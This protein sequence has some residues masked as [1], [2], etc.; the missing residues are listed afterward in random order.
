MQERI[1]IF[2]FVYSLIPGIFRL[3]DF[4]DSH[5]RGGND[6]P[7]YF[8]NDQTEIEKTPPGPRSWSVPE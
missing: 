3:A 2:Q 1:N 6:T 5:H 8:W 4:T 7:E